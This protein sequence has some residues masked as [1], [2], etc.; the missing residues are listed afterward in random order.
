MDAL[1]K[2][3]RFK[4]QEPVLLLNAPPEFVAAAKGLGA[5]HTAPKGSYPFVLAFAKSMADG[6]KVAKAVK[7]KL[8]EGAIFWM[9]YPKGTSKKY[10]ADINRDSGNAMMQDSGF[11]GVSLVAIDED[12]SAM[13]FKVLE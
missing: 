3:L 2:K 1:L 12:W 8:A 5:F 9:A 13:R 11:D 6:K 10:K 7:G 4:G